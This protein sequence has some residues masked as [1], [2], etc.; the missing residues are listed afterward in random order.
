MSGRRPPGELADYAWFTDIQTRWIDNDIYGHVNNVVY[1]S[2]FDTALAAYLMGDGGLDPWNAPVIGYAIENGCRFHRAV[3]FPD[4]IKAGVRVAHLGNTSVRY[5]IG[6]FKND[7]ATAAA[8]GHFVHVFVERA[9][10]RP[11][12]IPDKIRRALAALHRPADPA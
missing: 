2:F 6:I 7:D 11:V 10:G 4:R 1:Y 3:A 9:S 12:P 8:E 5:E